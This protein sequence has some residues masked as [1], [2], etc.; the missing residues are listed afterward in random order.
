MTKESESHTETKNKR[1]WLKWAGFGAILVGLFISL[2]LFLKS[3]LLF[4]YA[5]N[6]AEKQAGEILNGSLEI[7]SIRGDLL[8]GFTVYG[9]RVVDNQNETIATLDSASVHYRLLDVIKSPH[10]VEKLSI[11][12][13]DS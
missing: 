7:E 9:A 13:L 11:Y 2:R 4:N 5:R 10:T 6:F 8:N 3:D 12:G 1:R